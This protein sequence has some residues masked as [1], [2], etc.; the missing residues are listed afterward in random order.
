MSEPVREDLRERL[1]ALLRPGE[2]ELLGLIVRT[3]LSGEEELDLHELTLEVGELIAN[4]QEVQDWYVYSGNDSPEFA[5][6]QHQGLRLED[7]GFV[8][9]AQQLLREGTFDLVMYFEADIDAAALDD[10]LAKGGFDYEFVE[11]E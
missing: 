8:W 4:H 5:V 10:D 6:N 3:D 11:S 1:K 9:E 2:I 7:D